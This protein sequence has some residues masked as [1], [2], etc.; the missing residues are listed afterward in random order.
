[1][2]YSE[3]VAAQVKVRSHRKILVA[4][5]K[6]K[7]KKYEYILGQALKR[8]LNTRNKFEHAAKKLTEDEFVRFHREVYV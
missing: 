1:M 8:Q 4:I 2:L 6:H 3:F 7:K 5:P